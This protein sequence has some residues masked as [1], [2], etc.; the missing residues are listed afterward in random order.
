MRPPEILE[1]ERL[2]LRP[3]QLSDAADIFRYAGGVAETRFMPF[4]RHERF[5]E[6]LEFA[7][8]CEACWVSGSAFP[9]AITERGSGRFLG[10]I[11]LRLSPPK[12]DFGYI[13]EERFWGNGF[14]TE[15][16]TAV[17]H[18]ASAQPSILRVWA[19]CHAG[20][21]AS[22]AVLQKAGLNYEATLAN[23]EARPQL[24]EIAGSSDFYVL[25]QSAPA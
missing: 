16:A 2:R 10:V 19:T 17:T 1:T 5:A 12:A 14:A 11:E 8:R 24:G 18:W 9:W 6:S 20:N 21:V 3:V 4:R 23:W 22:A 25:T 7:E 13:F 15:A